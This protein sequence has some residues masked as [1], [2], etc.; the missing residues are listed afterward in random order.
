MLF[1]KCIICIVASVKNL[2][3]GYSFPFRYFQKLKNPLFSARPICLIFR[4]TRTNSQKSRKWKNH[5]NFG[6]FGNHGNYG[7]CR[8]Y[9]FQIIK[10]F[11]RYYTSKSIHNA[12]LYCNSSIF[13]KA[14]TLYLESIIAIISEIQN[15]RKSRKCKSSWT[16]SRARWENTE[17][18]EV[19]K[20]KKSL[21]TRTWKLWKS[22][23]CGTFFKL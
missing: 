22:Q 21:N 12:F 18:A 17:F 3:R 8:F 19:A 15:S 23:S 10:W 6:I 9:V 7:N 16:Q 14:F 2:I 4:W 1:G 13:F 11:Y 20:M 5:E